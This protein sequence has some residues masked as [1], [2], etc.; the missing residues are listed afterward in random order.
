MGSVLRSK[1][2]NRQ[3]CSLCVIQCELLLLTF[4]GHI[5]GNILSSAS[6]AMII[7][8]FWSVYLISNAFGPLVLNYLFIY[9]NAIQ[10]LFS[11]IVKSHWWALLQ[12]CVYLSKVQKVHGLR[13]QM[14]SDRPQFFM[15]G[16]SSITKW[17]E[18][19]IWSDAYVLLHFKRAKTPEK[20]NDKSVDLYARHVHFFHDFR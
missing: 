2:V 7:S 18:G 16:R 13:T 17:A 11:V 15:L 3:S 12:S 10:M 4:S 9:C 5:T 19:K 1:K 6:T 14:T 8:L 20:V